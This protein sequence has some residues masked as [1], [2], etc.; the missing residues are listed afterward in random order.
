M[1]QGDAAAHLGCCEQRSCPG[2]PPGKGLNHCACRGSFVGPPCTMRG[3]DGPV[4][5]EDT[6]LTPPIAAAALVQRHAIDTLWQVH[7][8]IPY[9]ARLLVLWGERMQ[10]CAITLLPCPSTQV[11]L[12]WFHRIVSTEHL[13][14]T[15]LL[16]DLARAWCADSP[17]PSPDSK[18]H[19]AA[20][21]APETPQTPSAARARTLS[22][23]STPCRCTR[24]RDN[25][26]L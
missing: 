6:R 11:R 26:E 9:V 3:S 17:H 20:T 7:T 5:A 1:Q 12:R 2:S 13:G 23:P 21:G 19:T 25:A 15:E 18:A 4:P 14:A 16:G 22:W 8:P 24:Q 10:E